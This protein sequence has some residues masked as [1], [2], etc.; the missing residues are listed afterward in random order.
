[1]GEW[2]YGSTVPDLG[3]RWEWVVRFTPRPFYSLRKTSGTHWMADWMCPRNG[4]DALPGIEPGPFSPYFI[5]IPTELSRFLRCRSSRFRFCC[6]PSPIIHN[7][8][9]W[10]NGI[11]CVRLTYSH[12][13]DCSH[14]RYNVVH[15]T[16]EG[17]YMMQS[18]RETESFER[19]LQR[20]FCSLLCLSLLP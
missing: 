12:N 13:I 16:E 15:V 5:T 6:F 7:V 17:N 20:N 2:T 3:T 11:L 14:V 9:V 1:M 18:W 10:Q 4:L 8:A 19:V